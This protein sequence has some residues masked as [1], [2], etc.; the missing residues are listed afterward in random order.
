MPLDTKWTQPKSASRLYEMDLFL[1]MRFAGNC[2]LKY[3]AAQ[4]TTHDD[5]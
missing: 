5:A 2:K 3:F 4:M 1:F